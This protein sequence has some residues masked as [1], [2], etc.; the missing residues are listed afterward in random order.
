MASTA[1]EED[2]HSASELP[3]KAV[4][5]I[6]ISHTTLI[7]IIVIAV[8]V[9]A[10]LYFFLNGM[11]NVYGDGVAH[12]NIARKVVD[13]ADASLRQRYIQIGS[14][15]LPV[16]TIMMLPLVTNDWLWRTG[17]AGSIVSMISFIIAALVLYRL[18]QKLYRGED[19]LS[20]KAL[21][22]LSLAIF[23]FN[24]SVLY[25]QTTPMSELVFMSA[26]IVAVYLLQC[27]R[28][29]QTT[30]R[31]AVAAIAVSFATL[32]RYE[33][34]PVALFSI[35]LV[36]LAASGDWKT[37][38]RATVTFGALAS[39][40]PLYW[41]W[42][43]WEIYGNALEFLSGPNSARGIAIQ[44]RVNFNWSAIFVGH[45]GLD[46]LTMA[47]TASVCAGPLVFL[48]GLAGFARSVVAKRKVLLE[49]SPPALLMV[50]FL[51]EVFGLYRGEIQIIPISAFG[52][53]NVRYGLPHMLGIAL[54]APAA[55]LLFNERSRR[56]AVIVCLVVVFAQYVYLISEGTTQLAIYQE[57]Y[58]NGVNARPSRERTR[59]ASFLKINPPRKMILMHTG[60]LGPLVSQGG[61]RFA[62]TIHEGTERWHQLGDGIPKDVMTVV[63]QQGDPLDLR[64]QGERVLNQSLS[65]EFTQLYS[66][67]NITVYE[68]VKK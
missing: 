19:P 35:L 65:A 60:A 31:L 58:R 62:D 10:F 18:A 51:F 5:S 48:L 47:A 49:Y 59:V 56:L 46:L 16:Q 53:L 22:A 12:V 6:T 4:I 41:L 17:A 13:S 21:P 40:G 14:P 66:A 44:N 33:A 15:W 57:G 26:L 68:R 63:V 67:G 8:S 7:T 2:H 3:H 28:D 37:K 1:L 36:T 38:V 64:I 42:H 24:P 29:D 55:V 9:S 32:T 45:A 20:T 11:T 43:N 23:V 54:F 30:R 39:I 61:L 25:L 50:P 27:W 34:W 52:L